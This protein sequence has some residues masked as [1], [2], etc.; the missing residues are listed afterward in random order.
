MPVRKPT[1]R[2]LGRGPGRAAPQARAP[3]GAAAAAAVPEDDEQY[4]AQYQQE[5]DHDVQDGV[6]QQALSDK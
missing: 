2:R 5:H 3:R 1:Q 4:Q 6:P